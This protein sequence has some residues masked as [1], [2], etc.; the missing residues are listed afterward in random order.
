MTAPELSP[1]VFTLC[2]LLVSVHLLGYLLERLK[3]PRLVGEILAGVI[4]GPFVLGK[5]TPAFYQRLFHSSVAGDKIE[6]VL[7]FLYWIGL[8]LLMFLSGSETR[9]ILAKENQK[10]TAWLLGIGTPLP[11]FLVIALGLSS[12]LPLKAIVGPAGQET[13]A[14]LVLAIAVAVTSIPVI[15]RIFLDLG[16]LHTRFASLIL[17]SAVLEDIIL[18]GVLAVATSLAGAKM[19]TDQSLMNYVSVH[20]AST[21]AYMGLGLFVAPKILA[22]L[23]RSRWNMLLKSSPIGYLFSIIFFYAAVAAVL[24]VNLIFAAFMAGFG[25]IGGLR[26][27]ERLRFSTQLDSISKVASGIF[28]PLYFVM[29]GHKLILG[30]DFSLLMFA[31]FLLASSIISLCSTAVA[32]KLAGFKGLDILNLAVTANARGGPGIVLAT[33][34]YE[35]KLINAP[36]YTTLVLTALVTSQIAGVWLRFILTKGLPLLSSHPHE[37]WAKEKERKE[38]LCIS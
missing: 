3:Q 26:E 24:D 20:V 13:S 38:D 9:K 29:V 25:A 21:V 30:R 23:H 8:I 36:F 7:H 28:I 2:V 12:L 27:N 15:S 34:A 31:T 33:I 35:A 16:I 4:F 11:F 32:A 5:L 22:K 6:I 37:T 18:W 14:L 19:L 17:G 10:E 1:I